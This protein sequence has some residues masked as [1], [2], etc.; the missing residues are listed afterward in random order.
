MN[1]L[2][3][4]GRGL[5]IAL[6]ATVVAAIGAVLIPAPSQAA[7]S[8]C[9]VA[10]ASVNIQARGTSVRAGAFNMEQRW[11]WNGQRITHVYKPTTWGSITG[12]GR[13]LGVTYE[14]VATNT[15][16]YFWPQNGGYW[17]RFTEYQ[18]KF[19]YCPPRILFCYSP[20]L[21]RIQFE[22]YGDG[23]YHSSGS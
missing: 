2:N 17:G 19:N 18:A 15:G 4:Y 6:C 23:V 7:A 3:R 16:Y 20:F 11:C 8:G 13:T 21:P 22:L 12:L 10:K 14:G 9:K 1:L 5:R